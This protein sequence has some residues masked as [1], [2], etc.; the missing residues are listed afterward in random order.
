MTDPVD[1]VR[2]WLDLCTRGPAAA[3]DGKV[4]PEIVI[5]LPFA[6]P[7]V[8]QEMH[9]R[10]QALAAME[11]TWVNRFT[12]HEVKILRTEDPELL[13]TTARSEVAMANGKPYENRYVMLTRVRGGQVVEHAEY[14]NPLPVMEA[15]GFGS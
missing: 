11:P 2:E 14:F 12:W 9:G 7:G 15:F 8:P 3:W 13:V 10:A 4:S 6:P 5:R 1:L